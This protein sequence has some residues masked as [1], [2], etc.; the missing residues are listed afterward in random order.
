M[1]DG[2]EPT[3][4]ASVHETGEGSEGICGALIATAGVK[5]I[6]CDPK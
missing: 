5:H 3:P 6:A 1:G 2:N 4:G